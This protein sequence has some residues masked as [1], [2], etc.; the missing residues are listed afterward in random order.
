M[1]KVPRRNVA[2]QVVANFRRNLEEIENFLTEDSTEVFD[3][4][5]KRLFDEVVP[6]LE[7]FSKLGGAFLARQPTSAKAL[8]AHR[9]LVGLA[10]KQH[11]TLREYVF[12][13]YICLYAEKPSAVYLLALRH[14]RQLSFDF[15]EHWGEP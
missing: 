10:K 4:L 6:N 3:A 14:H 1:P 5:L 2:V 8:A 12:D 15:P 13:S 9:R 11:V 7:Q